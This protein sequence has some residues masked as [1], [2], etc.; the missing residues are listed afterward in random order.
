[1][2]ILWQN[3]QQVSKHERA[4]KSTRNKY[5]LTVNNEMHENVSFNEGL[6]YREKFQETF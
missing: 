6:K 2:Y 3:L 5:S 4:H 1:M